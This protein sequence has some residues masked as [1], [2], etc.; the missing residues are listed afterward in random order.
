MIDLSSFV[1][2]KY[3]KL[4]KKLIVSD[5]VRHSRDIY[6]Q[7]ISKVPQSQPPWY[8]RFYN[9]IAERVLSASCLPPSVAGASLPPPAV[10]LPAPVSCISQSPVASAINFDSQLADSASVAD[11]FVAIPAVDE[12][13]TI[14]P[15]CTRSDSCN[16]FAER[17]PVAIGLSS[18]I[19]AAMDKSVP[20]CT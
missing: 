3:T 16:L 19:A 2:Q 10:A 5:T 7:H 17:S 8:T 13:N 12:M 18:S 20:D 14:P 9:E 15:T 6:V 1:F 11:S 4:M